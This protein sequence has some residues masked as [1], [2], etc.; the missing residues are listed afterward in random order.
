MDPERLCRLAVDY[1]DIGCDDAEV[2]ELMAD[3][4]PA[5]RESPLALARILRPVFGTSVRDMH[6]IHA[7]LRGVCPPAGPG[8]DVPRG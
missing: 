2:A 7:R 5:L 1:R 8:K 6:A 3:R 4:Y